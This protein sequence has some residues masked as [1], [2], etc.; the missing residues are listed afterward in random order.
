MAT[1]TTTVMMDKE[2][3]LRFSTNALIELEEVLGKPISSIGEDVAM[4]DIRAMFYVGL[5]WEDK[6]ITMVSTGDLIDEALEHQDF[7][8]L[9]GELTKAITSAIGKA[10]LPSK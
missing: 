10:Q 5:K 2:R 9:A 4:S 6:K 3:H 1:K 8:E 7:E